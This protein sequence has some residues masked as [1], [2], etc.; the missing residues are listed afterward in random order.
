MVNRNSPSPLGGCDYCII[1]AGAAGCAL[2]ARLSEN[3]AVRVTLLE[4]G[5][6][7]PWICNVPL[8][9][10]RRMWDLSWQYQNEPIRPPS[11]SAI[12][13][14]FGKVLGGSSSINAM[15]YCRGSAAA[16]DRWEALGNP[17]WSFEDLLP[18]FR[19]SETFADGASRHHGED[20]PIHVSPPRHRAPFSEAFIEAC[21]E[22]GISR[23]NDF[24]C[25]DPAGAGYYHVMQK[26]G[27]R[28][29]AAGGYLRVAKRRR[30]LSVITGATVARIVIDGLQARGVEWFDR[31]GRAHHTTA[32]SE[33]ILCAGAF[34]SPKI[35]MLS[36]IGP[37]GTLRA[38][39]L[40]P[41]I[42]LPGVGQCLQDHVRV[43]VLF[44]SARRSPGHWLNWP[45][46]AIQYA[47][48]RRGVLTS[49]CC[50][51]GAMVRS[52]ATQPFADV[53]FVTHFQSHL[54]PHAVDLQFCLARTYSRGQVTLA[55]ADPADPPRIN[56]NY[57]DH[58][59]DMRAAIWALR[60]AREIAAAPALRGF[61]ITEEISP[62]PSATDDAALESHIWATAETCYHP[63]CT[64]RMGNDD[65]AVVD[66][67]L[68]VRGIDRLRI[69]DASIMPELP[70]GNTC[71]PTY[72]IAEKAASLIVCDQ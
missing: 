9:S 15:M 36:G 66:S 44:R 70:N 31:D 19:K 13:L 18:W 61:G 23:I 7:D 53:Q 62:G 6:V 65:L 41:V 28:S 42:D 8:A 33:V 22:I 45:G 60:R 38:L 40:T 37:A 52:D 10:L 56:L 17:G 64:C 55:S 63:A 34:N 30:N 16:Y 68:R 46:A 20:G 39:N 29:S 72:M 4:A 43:P 71:A 24:N 12:R 26:A 59:A 32:D 27:R 14:P 2:A 69:A 35:L 11:R 25:D 48:A 50:E 57:F 58:P 3:P 67:S 5:G 47:I 54:L 1:G 51:A 49:N 21:Q